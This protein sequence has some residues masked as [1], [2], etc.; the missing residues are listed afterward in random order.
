MGERCFDFI[1]RALQK[2][3][4]FHGRLE[5]SCPAPNAL[6]AGLLSQSDQIPTGRWYPSSKRCACCGHTLGRLPLDVRRWS[7]PEC[8]T[9]HD[10]DVNAAINV[11]AAGLAVLALG[12][13]VSGMGQVSV[14]CSR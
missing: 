11:K 12:E 13:N 2:G 3:Q 4:R 8:A 9:E 6:K 14:S 1:A 7:C 10:R 5:Q